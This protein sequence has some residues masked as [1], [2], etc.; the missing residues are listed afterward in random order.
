MMTRLATR[1]GLDPGNLTWA[2]TPEP[3]GRNNSRSAAYQVSAA[4]SDG[5]QR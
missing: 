2:E 4:D 1:Y 5:Q 3:V